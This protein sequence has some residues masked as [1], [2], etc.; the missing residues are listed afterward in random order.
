MGMLQM[1]AAG[2]DLYLTGSNVKGVITSDSLSV[3]LGS[4]EVVVHVEHLWMQL[5]PP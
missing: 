2:E 3:W 5:P 4:L 1:I